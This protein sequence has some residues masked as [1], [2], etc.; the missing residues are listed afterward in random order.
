MDINQ[1]LRKHTL[2]ILGIISTILLF[3]FFLIAQNHDYRFLSL[4]IKWIAAALIPLILVLLLGKYIK[5]FKWGDF[6]VVIDQPLSVTALLVQ[7]VI[8]QFV[9]IGKGVV[10][11]LYSLSDERRQN[12]TLL[13]FTLSVKNYY[14]ADAVHEYFRAFPN[15]KF[16]EVKRRSGQF[17]CLIKKEKLAPDIGSD[18][19]LIKDFIKAVE[20][21]DITYLKFIGTL[22][23]IPN[24][25][26]L[27]EAYKKLLSSG[28]D[29]AAAISEN[30]ILIG[31]LY[32]ASIESKIA[33]EFLSYAG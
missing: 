33:R 25:T 11:Q 2:L 12:T 13:S 27:I 29:Y 15:L 20:S 28:Q 1:F 8:E 5:S 19:S 3:V 24:D 26:K 17:V 18:Y 6:E 30:K 21:G 7:P 32:L 4:D 23:A 31:I 22:L 16:L 9:S 10:D 14:E